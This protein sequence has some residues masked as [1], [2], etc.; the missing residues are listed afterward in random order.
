MI[1]TKAPAADPHE[2]LSATPVP[3]ET[4]HAGL[5]TG[6]GESRMMKTLA[7]M[8]LLGA[9][10][11][12]AP[13]EAQQHPGQQPLQLQI[14]ELKL[15]Q[16]Q[17]QLMQQQQLQQQQIQ[18]QQL[19]SNPPPLQQQQFQLQQSQQQQLQE[20]QLESLRLQQ[21]RL[22]RTQNHP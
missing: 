13:V 2:T 20:Q 16:S 11:V 4:E 22:Q 21:Q 18:Q 15:Q 8:V 19:Q 17:Q 9:V 10:G 14:Q 3:N 12:Y 5:K 1:G 6:T 7:R